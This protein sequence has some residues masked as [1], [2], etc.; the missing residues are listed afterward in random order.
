MNKKIPLRMCIA[1]REMKEKS[2]LLKI[3][4]TKEGTI[5][6]DPS[7]KLAGRGAYICNNLECNKKLHKQKLLNRTFSMNVDSEVYSQIEEFYKTQS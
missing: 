4:K 3:V 6:V 7:G 1:C 5:T 2:Q